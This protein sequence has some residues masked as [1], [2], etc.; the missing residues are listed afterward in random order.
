LSSEKNEEGEGGGRERKKRRE[1]GRGEK[2]GRCKPYLA[3]VSTIL[4]E[5]PG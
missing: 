2:E 5:C 1:E 4:K 3:K